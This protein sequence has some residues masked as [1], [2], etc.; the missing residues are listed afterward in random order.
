MSD[1]HAFSVDEVLEEFDT[2]DSGIGDREAFARQKRYGPNLLRQ[3]KKETLFALFLR[4][5][6]SVVI[7]VMILVFILAMAMQKWFEASAIFVV[8]FINTLIGFISEWKARRTIE[9]LQQMGQAQTKVVRNG[10]TKSVSAEEVVPG[11]ILMLSGNEPVV[12]DARIVECSGLRVDEAALTGESV[13]VTKENQKVSEETEIIDRTN[14][15]FKGTQISDGSGMAV[16]VATGNDTEIGKILK[17]TSQAKGSATP[18]QKQ[19][20]ILG[21][22]IAFLVFVVALLIGL[23]G[24]FTGKPLLLMIETAIALGVAAVPE[25]L[26][27]V[28]VIALARG[29]YIMAKSNALMNHLQAVE[30]LGSTTIIFAD[31]TG[32]LTKN[33][34]VT[35][36]IVTLQHDLALKKSSKEKDVKRDLKKA[37]KE[38]DD[39]LIYQLLAV[40]MLCNN[41]KLSKKEKSGDPMEVALIETGEMIGLSK[42]FL[43]DK[44]PECKEVPFDR[45]TMMMATFHKADSKLLVAVKGAPEA[46]ISSCIDVAKDV[47]KRSKM[48]KE[49]KKQWLDA[50]STLASSGLRLLAFAEKTVKKEEDPYK[51]LT[52][53]GLV[54]FYDPPAKQVLE[55]I[56][57]CKKAG[58]RVIMM[59]GDKPET[60]EAIAKEVGISNGNVLLGS[61][62]KEH[63]DKETREKIHD[64]NIF[65]R[66]TPEQKLKL[67]AFFQKYKEVVAVTGD[68]VNDAPALKKADIGIAMGKRGTDAARQVADMILKNDTFNNIAKAVEQGR[69]IFSNIR[70]SVMFMLCTN[71]AEIFAVALASFTPWPLP[72]RP[73]QILFLNV[74]TDVLPALALGL[75]KGSGNEMVKPPREKKEMIITK[76]H[77]ISIALWSGIIGVSVLSGLLSG[78]YWLHIP[79]LQAVTVSF[80]VLG[81]SKLWFV[82]NLKD[83]ESS[84]ITNEIT[85]NKWIWSALITCIFFLVLAIYL[86]FLSKILETEKISLASWL[87]VMG[88][89]LIPFMVGQINLWRLKRK[90]Y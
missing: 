15:V 50:T 29:M 42:S 45:K 69:V 81:F 53:L 13:P 55:S 2:Q 30:T 21:R 43:L 6:K 80:L 60:A 76:R 28:A 35:G 34:M 11:D 23:F 36:R 49:M 67:V 44:Y 41:A 19:L 16:V 18:L 89:S 10:K 63:L 26:P 12:A 73:M 17:L 37:L 25:G 64:A 32:T 85:K 71:G 84:F 8:I 27:I 68:G 86:P 54:A 83:K 77:W 31:K 88:F 39:P 72:L 56:D 5:Y 48:T 79:P 20:N 75:G 78:L 62:L 14:M 57:L 46:V 65:A 70:K 58:I 33:S 47:K 3:Q 24:F 59:T 40:S 61:D 22:Y 1:W 74:L 82:F 90:N 7:L 52:L 51:G 4:Q 38:N 66:V 9:A 87:V